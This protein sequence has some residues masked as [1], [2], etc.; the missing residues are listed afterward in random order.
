MIYKRGVHWHLDVTI[1]G[2]RYR[3][4]LDTTDG[5]KAKELEKDRVAEIKQ[6]KGA[7]KSGQEFAR[8][9]FKEAATDYLEDRKPR[10]SERTCQFERER[11][12]PLIKHFQGSHS[13]G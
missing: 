3:E 7:S 13:A 1:N 4:A 12:G 8:K 10:V 2:V 5:R 9:S 11:L 6:G